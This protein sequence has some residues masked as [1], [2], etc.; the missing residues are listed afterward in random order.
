MMLEDLLYIYEK[1]LGSMGFGMASTCG[2]SMLYT[3]LRCPIRPEVGTVSLYNCGQ[4]LY[5][6]DRMRARV[7]FY[8]L[9]HRTG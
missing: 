9:L 4:R 8:Q 6:S 1:R 2:D 5:A 7:G 3:G